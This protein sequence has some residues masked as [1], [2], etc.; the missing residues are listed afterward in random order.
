MRIPI[1][2]QEH[3]GRMRHMPRFVQEEFVIFRVISRERDVIARELSDRLLALSGRRFAW[4][5][6]IMRWQATVSRP[7]TSMFCWDYHRRLVVTFG[8]SPRTRIGWSVRCGTSAHRLGGGLRSNDSWARD[9][10]R[11]RCK[12]NMP[13][14][15]WTA[16]YRGLVTDAQSRCRCRNLRSPPVASS[17]RRTSLCSQRAWR[18][19]WP[20]RCHL[21]FTG[22]HSSCQR[23]RFCSS[24]TR[25]ATPIQARCCS[26][27]SFVRLGKRLASEGKRTLGGEFAVP[28]A[29]NDLVPAG[30]AA[31][32]NPDWK[33]IRDENGEVQHLDHTPSSLSA[34]MR[35]VAFLHKLCAICAVMICADRF[36]RDLGDPVILR[37][38][39][40]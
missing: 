11:W 21:R 28:A 32:A 15:T 8:R 6:W 37:R 23:S 16:C 26:G 27:R 14:I 1:D 22:L 10:W 29:A 19:D 35:K 2:V 7:M 18:R 12:G 40:S 33:T 24:G 25:V 4:S 39:L 31:A 5:L 9:M 3:D 30:P 20:P 13:S 36:V 34:A 17:A 38:H